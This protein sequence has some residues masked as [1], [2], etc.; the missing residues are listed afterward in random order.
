MSTVT[1]VVGVVALLVGLGIMYAINKMNHAKQLT[2]IEFK[3]KKIVDKAKKDA[4]EIK[5][6]ARKDA[7]KRS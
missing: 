5:Y 4:N 2:E 7:T 6:K 3:K 1:I